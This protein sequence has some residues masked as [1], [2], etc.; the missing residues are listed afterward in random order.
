MKS[1]F[2][3]SGITALLCLALWKHQDR[4]YK[5]PEAISASENQQEK[6]HPKGKITE[7]TNRSAN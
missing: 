2:C 5:G 4:A 1:D 3:I 6:V 7:Q